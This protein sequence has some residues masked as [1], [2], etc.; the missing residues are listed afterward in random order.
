MEGNIDLK[1]L[2]L[3]ELE[4]VVNI[5]PWFALA[6]MELCR[7]M[8]ESGSLSD[9]QCA[10]LAMYLPSRAGIRRFLR[11][12]ESAD[13]ADAAV[14]ELVRAYTANR[15]A[16]VVGG[17]YFSQG[18]YDEVRRDSDSDFSF[19]AR[20]SAPEHNGGIVEDLGM[21]T[22]TLAQ[23][24]ADQG[25]YDQAKNIYSKLSLAYPEKSAYFAS[26]IENFEKIKS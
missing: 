1:K 15:S 23:I 10:D 20:Q 13:C 3:E 19:T 11:R 17:D 26:L 14:G 22:E 7:R 16:R 6:R 5:Y 25:Y 18:E 21:Y 2:T 12:R 8:A 24:Y 4:G 9:E